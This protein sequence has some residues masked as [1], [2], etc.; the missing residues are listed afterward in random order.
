MQQSRHISLHDFVFYLRFIENLKLLGM[1]ALSLL[2]NRCISCEFDAF[3]LNVLLF[4]D[5]IQ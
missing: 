2:A 3:F 4:Y 1:C 5:T